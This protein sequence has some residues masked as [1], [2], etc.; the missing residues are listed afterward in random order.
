MKEFFINLLSYL[1]LK[2]SEIFVIFGHNLY[3]LNVRNFFLRAIGVDIKYGSGIDRGFDFMF[4]GPIISI[5]RN[6]RIGI[7]NHF[8][9]YG[10]IYIGSCCMF[11]ADVVLTN[12][13]HN[14]DTFEPFSGPILIHDGCWIGARVTIVGPLTIGK[15]SIVAAGAVVINDVPEG[16]VVAG[17]PARVIGQRNL[18][19]IACRGDICF[20]TDTFEVTSSA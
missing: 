20:S 2:I 13:G 19:K 4:R 9:N 14:R 15:N 3:S 12:G 8:W 18:P 16:S 17:V 10:P 5:G 11:A 1:T 7:K 6:T